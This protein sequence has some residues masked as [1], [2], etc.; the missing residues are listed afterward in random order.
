LL[1]WLWQALSPEGK[2]GTRCEWLVRE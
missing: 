1:E 2:G